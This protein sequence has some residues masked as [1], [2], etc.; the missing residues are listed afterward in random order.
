M[1]SDGGSVLLRASNRVLDLT[2]RLARCFSDYRDER[3]TEH[4]VQALVGQRVYGLA[5]GYEDL[6]ES[7]PAS[8]RQ[9]V[10]AGA[11][12]RRCEGGKLGC[13]SATAVIRWRGSSTLNRLELGEPE[14]AAEH[15]VQENGRA[16]RS[17]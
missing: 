12:A 3:R 7:R 9:R 2:A 5:L 4:S 1:S 16:P 6:N 8:R 14:L 11:G 13:V 15:R 10:G 17:A